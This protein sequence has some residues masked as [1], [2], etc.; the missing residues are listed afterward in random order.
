[1]KKQKQRIKS[2]YEEGMCDIFHKWLE[3]RGGEVGDLGCRREFDGW[4][5]QLLLYACL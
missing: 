2:G 1:M 3:S 5:I 4:P